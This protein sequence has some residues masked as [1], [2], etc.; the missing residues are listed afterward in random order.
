VQSSGFTL[1]PG[2]GNYTSLIG[3]F[4]P[5]FGEVGRWASGRVGWAPRA[6]T[7]P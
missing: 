4:L 2:I 6:L 1:P 5:P 7:G 3:I